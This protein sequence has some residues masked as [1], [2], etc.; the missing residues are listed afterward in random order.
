MLTG[1]L[2]DSTADSYGHQWAAFEGFCADNGWPSLPTTAAAVSCYV[3]TL[4]ERHVSQSTFDS[5]LSPVNGRHVAAWLPKPATGRLVQDLRAGY[6]RMVADRTNVFPFERAPLPAPVAWRIVE[7]ASR[8][9]DAAW[10]AR[11][12]AVVL[13]FVLTRRTSEVLE[14]PLQDVETTAD[15]GIRCSVLRYEGGERRNTVTRLVFDFRTSP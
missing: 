11:F 14:L 13:A 4:C 10:R 6:A 2:A 3:G 5:Y 8:T 12:T 7:L 15:G 1:A 9:P